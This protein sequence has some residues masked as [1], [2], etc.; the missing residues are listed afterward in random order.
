MSYLQT[1][2]V[3]SF[4]KVDHNTSADVAV[5]MR[6]EIVKFL[7]SNPKKKV[8][9]D[10]GGYTRMSKDFAEA[11]FDKNVM[12][13][14]LERIGYRQMHVFDRELIALVWQRQD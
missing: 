11:L 7:E 10:F 3:V 8:T 12:H 13:K 14:Y 5:N 1:E 6:S 2:G 4:D 9:L